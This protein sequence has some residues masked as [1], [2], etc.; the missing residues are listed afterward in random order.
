MNVSPPSVSVIVPIYKVERYLAQCVDSILAQ[1]LQEIEV[2]LVDDGSPD[3][4]PG[5][6]DAYAARDSRVRVIHQENRGA[7]PARNAGLAAACG[8]YAIFLDADD[9]YLPQMLERM[10]ARARRFHADVVICRA[11]SKQASGRLRSLAVQLR[12]EY[13]RKCGIEAFCPRQE[14]PE[15]LFQFC[16]GWPWDK[17]YRRDFLLNSGLRYQAL[18]HTNDAY[19]VYMSLVK[20]A[21]VSVVPSVLVHHVQHA[22]STSRSTGQDTTCLTEALLAIHREIQPLGNAKLEKS[23]NHWAMNMAVWHY[24]QVAGEAAAALQTEFRER[25]EPALQLLSKGAAYY[26]RKRDWLRYKECVAPE[27]SV[28]IP[29]YNAAAYMSAAL[30]SL[31]AQSFSDWEAICVNDGSTDDSLAIL[32]QY[33]ERDRRI[34]IIDGPNGGYGRAMNR[35]MDAAGGKYLAI[36]EPDDELPRN[37]YRHLYALAEKHGA[38]IAKGCVSRFVQQGSRRNYVETTRIPRALC[39]LP[40]CPQKQQQAFTLCM[41]T[42]TCLYNRKFLEQHGIRHHETPGA[43]YQDNGLFF[44]SFAH[45]QKLIC[46]N[47]VVYL[48]RRDNAGSSV[49]AIGRRPYAMRDEYAYIRRE[50]EKTPELWQQLRPAWL[51]KRLD[52]H[53]FTYSHLPAEDKAA[54]LADLKAELAEMQNASDCSFLAAGGRG[55]M[56]ILAT[57]EPDSCASALDTLLPTS[58]QQQTQR[59]LFCTRT[60]YKTTWHLCGIPLW[61]RGTKAGR[62]TWR[63]LGIPVKRKKHS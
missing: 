3:S 50:L 11:E 20:A 57:R 63:V 25:L 28:V 44:L 42:W 29:V 60:P 39:A 61:S 62:T 38:D 34:R 16:A 40:I 19:F 6:C 9:I 49:H 18:R 4:C 5:M 36:L 13:L 33:A 30:D 47:E 32:Q 56:E 46:T 41:N 17:L 15:H 24:R 23:F 48:C 45:A 53:F 43:A 26:P 35:G 51:R 2:I 12:Q 52:N 14:I 55:A 8:E 27:I 22:E 54:Y 58:P 21:V 59:S 1:T 37:A 10:V 7:G 31:L